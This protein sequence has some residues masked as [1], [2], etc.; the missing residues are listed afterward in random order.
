MATHD[1][2]LINKFPGTVYKIE[3]GVVDQTSMFT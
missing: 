2:R 3:D 1:Y